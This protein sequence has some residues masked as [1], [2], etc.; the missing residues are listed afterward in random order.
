[1]KIWQTSRPDNLRS[2]PNRYLEPGDKNLR[3]HSID[4]DM[5]WTIGQNDLPILKSKMKGLLDH[6]SDELV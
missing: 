1:M 3:M 5:I 4:V 6:G 2:L